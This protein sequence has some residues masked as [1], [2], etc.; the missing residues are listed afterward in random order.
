LGADL[1]SATVIWLNAK[2]YGWKFALWISGLFYFG[3]A[4]SGLTVHYLFAAFDAIPTARPESL[5][6]MMQVEFSFTNHT[7]VLNLIFGI[8]AII[9]LLIRWRATKA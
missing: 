4:L 5:Q 1:I 6:Q 9:L 8:V 2:Y 3:M 7:F